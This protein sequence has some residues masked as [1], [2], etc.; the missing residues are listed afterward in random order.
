MNPNNYA[1]LHN[2]WKWPCGSATMNNWSPWDLEMHRNVEYYDSTVSSGDDLPVFAFKNLTPY[3]LTTFKGGGFNDQPL[4]P[5]IGNTLAASTGSY[6][7]VIFNW[8]LFDIYEPANNLHVGQVQVKLKQTQSGDYYLAVT[9]D[10]PCQNPTT[11]ACSWAGVTQGLSPGAQ[12]SLV[13]NGNVQGHPVYEFHC[14]NCGVVNCGTP[15][16]PPA[17]AN[18][19]PNYNWLSGM[20]N[21]NTTPVA[22]SSYWMLDYGSEK[23]RWTVDIATASIVQTTQ[24][25]PT[26]QNCGSRAY[27]ATLGSN[28][29][30]PYSPGVGCAKS[31]CWQIEIKTDGKYD[32]GTDACITFYLAQ[33]KNNNYAPG[34]Q[35]YGDGAGSGGN[36]LMELDIFESGW[37]PDGP[38]YNFPHP[39]GAGQ[40]KWTAAPDSSNSNVQ[41]GSWK[42][43]STTGVLTDFVTFG[44]YIDDAQPRKNCWMYAYKPN[45]QQWYCSVPIPNSGDLLQNDLVPYIGVWTKTDGDPTWPKCLST[46]PEFKTFYR[47]FVY[48]PVSAFPPGANPK[49]NPGMFGPVLAR[50]CYQTRAATQQDATTDNWAWQKPA[51]I[52]PS[53][54][55]PQKLG[56]YVARTDGVPCVSPPQ[57]VG[58]ASNDSWCYTDN[59]LSNQWPWPAYD[60]NKAAPWGYCDTQAPYPGPWIGPNDQ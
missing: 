4:N 15:G 31:G 11:S 54:T 47:N 17:A 12:F 32:G 7:Y 53:T 13:Q 2:T 48:L 40:P 22:G 34:P 3:N 21:D 45:G 27:P 1:N 46:T 18:L 8:M 56:Y 10:P 6:D 33:R 23:E 43:V 30:P 14:L 19:I 37:H 55:A 9:C 44:C 5:A 36:F 16:P 38:Q 41:G 24:K 59:T 50:T 20:R 35:N 26:T 58:M 39:G 52:G 51:A 29:G 28:T 49:S 42:D 57:N 60:S 25:D